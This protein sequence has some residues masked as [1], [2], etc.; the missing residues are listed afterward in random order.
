M[1]HE[2]A[3]EA[4]DDHRDVGEARDLLDHHEARANGLTGATS[5]RPVLES[6]VKL[7]NSSSIQLRSPVGSTAAV[8]LPGSIAWQTV[9]V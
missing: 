6:V 4:G 3:D 7:R 5:L 2:Q 8:K 1:E 9:Y